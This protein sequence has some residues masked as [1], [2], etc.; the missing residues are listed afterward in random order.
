MRLLGQPLGSAAYAKTFFQKKME[1]N[2]QDAEK[3]LDAVPDLQTALRLYS[4]CTLHK[5]PHLL[6]AEVMY[7]HTQQAPERWDKWEGPLVEGIGKMTERFLSRLTQRASIPLSSLTIAHMTI[8]QGGLAMMD[9]ATRAIPDFIL[10]MSQAVRIAE[11]GVAL[12]KTHSHKL[13]PSLCAL[14]RTR[15]NQGS[16]FLKRFYT[17]LP[18]VALVAAPKQSPDPLD[19][20]LK[21]G[22]FKSARDRLR[23]AASARR[24]LELVSLA[25]EDPDPEFQKDL[26]E[27]LIASSSYPIIHM[28]RSDKRNRRPNDLLI[29]SLKRKLH[30][31]IFD[32]ARCPTCVC[33]KKIDPFGKHT[34]ACRYVSKKSAH[35][36][37]V[38]GTAPVIKE[39]L[40]SSGIIGTGSKM[41]VEP[42]SVVP[43][44]PRL[45]PLDMSFRPV[46]NL[47]NTHVPMSPFSEVGLDVTIASPRGHCPPSKQGAASNQSATAAKHQHLVSK[48]R[49]KLAR[50]GL[51]DPNSHTS[52]T[53][54]QIMERLMESG[55][56][57]IPW[58]ISPYGKWG[59]CSTGSF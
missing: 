24:R 51:S 7:T 56:V 45:R 48:E 44:L 42:K 36:R 46:P 18:A 26:A 3:L 16:T 58:A 19:Y 49:Q 25:G 29:L 20:L 55:K 9:A 1:E 41:Y 38:W 2:S 12:S 34:F 6:G 43:E 4:Q 8:A 15:T 47:R 14:F 31:E 11:Q 53:G 5:L 21:N 28:S 23:Q 35:D 17:L 59:A 52:L 27:I 54:E 32:P 30:L 22:P 57:L 40:L 37:I 13:A 33:G 10:T 39:L 50:E